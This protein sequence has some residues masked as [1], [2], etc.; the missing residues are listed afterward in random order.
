[1]L[2]SNPMF[3]Q[4][5]RGLR[6]FESPYGEH[7]MDRERKIDWLRG[8]GRDRKR[9]ACGLAGGKSWDEQ[10]NTASHDSR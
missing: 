1:M 6:R 7:Q 2:V 8:R 3:S 9:V 5:T 4:N 10:H